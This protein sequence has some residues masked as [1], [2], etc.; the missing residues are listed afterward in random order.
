MTVFQNK[1]ITEELFKDLWTKMINETVF[2]AE[3][4]KSGIT[5]YFEVNDPD[6][7]MY[8]DGNGPLFGDQARAKVPVV[9]MQMS[10]DTVHKFWLKQ[11]NIP[12][13]LALRHIKAK[14]PV[15]KVLQVLPLLKPGQAIYPEYCRKYNLP[16]A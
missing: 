3:L 1:E 4:N 15:S 14:G 10:G 6:I 7:V 16:L 9:T 13:A 2:G 5:I 11:V 12:K 8:V